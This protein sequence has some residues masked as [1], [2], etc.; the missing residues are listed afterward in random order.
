MIS[1]PTP[2]ANRLHPFYTTLGEG[3]YTFQGCYDLGEALNPN[4]AAN[5][6]N[7]R[8]WLAGAPRLKAGLGT[9]AHCGQG[10]SI[11]CIVRTGNGDLYGIGSDCVEKCST[12]GIWRGVKAAIALRRRDKARAKSAAKAAAKREAERPAREA[13]IAASNAAFAAA[14]AEAKGNLL[15]RIDAFE[16]V[17]E[18]LV[19]HIV[20]GAW[21]ADY[22]AEVKHTFGVQGGFCPPHDASN[23]GQS[24]AVQLIAT[25]RLSPRQAYFAAKIVVGNP[26]KANQEAFD[27]LVQHLSA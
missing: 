25:G 26:K 8:G 11:I 19:G 10:I 6:G 2:A 23:F 17:L 12:G 4:S 9:C 14:V 22:A 5:F 21:R 7:Q 20:L 15:A 24:L 3:P 1:Q 16:G 27:D 13:A 18:A